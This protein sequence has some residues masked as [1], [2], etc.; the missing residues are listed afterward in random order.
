MKTIRNGNAA[1]Q[2]QARA[3][4][5]EYALPGWPNI[6]ARFADLDQIADY[7]EG[8]LASIGLELPPLRIGSIGGVRSAA[9]GVCERREGERMPRL[10]F[11]PDGRTEIVVLHELA[12]AVDMLQGDARAVQADPPHGRSWQRIYL[13]LV[14]AMLGSSW[15]AAL[16]RRFGVDTPSALVL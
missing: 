12:H 3:Y 5:A 4:A 14:D 11:A 13:Q 9:L 8:A 2:A 15:H 6:G 16:A 10:A 1:E 7:C